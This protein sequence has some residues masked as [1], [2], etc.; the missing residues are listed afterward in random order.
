[1]IDLLSADLLSGF[2][3]VEVFRRALSLEP[4]AHQV[5]YLRSRRPMLVLK[6]RQTGFSTTAA[7]KAIHLCWFRPNVLAAI[8]SPSQ[9]QSENVARIAR[10]GL[11]ALGARLEADSAS[12][13]KL[14]NG[15]RIVSLPGTAK[16]VRGFTAQLLVI[17]EAAYVLPETW[18]AARP[19]IA[20]GGQL[21][22]QSTPNGQAGD[23]W[24]LWRANDPT[25]QRFTLRSDEVPTISAA[26]LA[27]ELAELGS[28]GFASEYLCEFGRVGVPSL[29]TAER[30]AR[31]SLPPKE[32]HG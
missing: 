28:D 4:M 15:S 1:M 27:K 32:S 17:D 11:R 6:G 13:I 10:Q 31:W 2:D 5:D 29:F 12:N 21:I 23:F 19:L 25:W 3:P 9:K 22:V 7:A 16:S 26:F 24:D 18:V 14:A 30:L 20:T 8:I